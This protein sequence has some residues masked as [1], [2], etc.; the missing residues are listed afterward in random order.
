MRKLAS[1]VRIDKLYPIEGADRIELAT[2]Q[3]KAWQ[4]VVKKDE[5]K[6]NDFAIYFEID[7]MLPLENPAFEFLRGRNEYTLASSTNS[8]EDEIDF[9]EKPENSE[10]T[11]M[12]KV[13]SRLK[14]IKLRKTLSQGLL[15]PLQFFD[16]LMKLDTSDDIE[17]TD[18]TESLGV[19]KYEIVEKGC[20]AGKRKGSFP[21]FIPKTD[22]E[23]VQNIKRLYQEAAD[24]GEKFE[25][26][27]KIDGSSMTVYVVNPK[28]VGL[29]GDEI[30]TGVC[31]KNLE[32]EVSPDSEGLFVKTY[33]EK[34]IEEKLR[35]YYEET[36]RSIAPQG[37][38]VGPTIQKNFEGLDSV[39]YYI[40]KVFDIDNQVVLG[41]NEAQDIAYVLGLNYV[42][43]YDDCITLPA[44]IEEL[45]TMA[46]GPSGLNGK[47]REGLVFKSLERTFSFKVISNS[48]LLKTGE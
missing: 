4:C 21:R 3:G 10:T 32:L 31:S 30:K 36:G 38:L 40:Y 7:S 13:Y 46:E 9:A 14:T 41:P 44:T 12:Y 45:L 17:G 34:G 24:S 39:N 28:I 16:T 42:P 5:F 8:E 25:C 23:R 20:S 29:E 43:V 47:F 2:I 1:I 26:T 15:L 22:E 19:I 33:I 37:E 27:Y 35:N 18:V 11:T 6:E 48:Y